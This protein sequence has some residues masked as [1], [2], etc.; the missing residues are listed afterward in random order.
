MSKIPN[1]LKL[2]IST[3]FEVALQGIRV[4]FGRSVVT[5]SG[6][7]LGIAFLMSILTAEV[8]KEGVAEEQDTRDDVRRM[9][10]FLIAETGPL[11]DRKLAIVMVGPLNVG[12][13]RLLAQI[14][15]DG[16]AELIGWAQQPAQLP[17]GI[18][19]V[20]PAELTTDTRGILVM[21]DGVVSELPWQE[22]LANAKKP[23]VCASRNGQVTADLPKL[24]SLEREL[25]PE[26]IARKDA[27]AAKARV[28]SIWII[29]SSML[30]TVIGITNS[31]L[32]SVTERF[33]E[34][35]TMKCL[36]ALSAFIRQ[37]FL[38]ES[39]FIGLVGAFLGALTGTIFSLAAYMVT[40][41]PGLVLS[42]LS[43]PKL[44]AHFA[45]AVAVGLILSI[46]AAL[47]PAR[48]ASKMLPAH[49]LR[50]NV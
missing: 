45:F 30:V 38:V 26:E 44:A 18:T 13:T 27:D 32:M 34:I 48:F 49:A 29:I 1:Q 31:M 24:V 35:G 7:L 46:M 10:N 20:A 40:Y 42:S 36:G 4:R 47:Y 3:A 37:L 43:L 9:G 19:P 50:S 16:P 22:V 25:R 23:L 21:G 8:I 5:I 2:P 14:Q 17:A 12:E 15:A 39:S 28:R 33:R 11:L 41:S 6:V